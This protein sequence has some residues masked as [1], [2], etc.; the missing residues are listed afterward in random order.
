MP[1]EGKT[2][3]EPKR[4]CWDSCVFLHRIQRTRGKIAILEQ[5]TYAAEQGKVI[6]VT[7]ALSIAEVAKLDPLKPLTT[8]QERDIDEF[9][10]NEYIEIV[11]VD[12][13]VAEVARSIVRNHKLKPSDAVIVASALM[14]EA[15]VLHT[16]D[17]K[18]L[19]RD[20][21]IGLPGKP[22]LEIVEPTDPEQPDLFAGSK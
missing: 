20:G 3:T 14:G 13:F 6:F 9:F 22:L 7:S 4:I 19:K 11:T 12:R 5:I 8:K 21:K 17:E 1:T 15:A 16:Y 18:V 10:E 2:P